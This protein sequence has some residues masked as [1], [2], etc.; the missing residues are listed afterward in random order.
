MYGVSPDH[1]RRAHDVDFGQSGCA[2]RKGL[3]SDANAREVL[4]D[5]KSFTGRVFYYPSLQPVLYND[6][7]HSMEAEWERIEALGA[8][9]FREADIV[10]ATVE[11]LMFPVMPPERLYT[12]YRR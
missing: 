10:V 3:S 4:E 2:Q 5:L 12:H 7:V 9:I 11:A 8:L 1:R 6:M